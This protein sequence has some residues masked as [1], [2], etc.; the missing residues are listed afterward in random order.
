MGGAKVFDNTTNI[1]QFEMR[2]RTGMHLYSFLFFK[3]NIV[4][5]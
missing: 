1:A 3:L 2:V 5:I 4:S